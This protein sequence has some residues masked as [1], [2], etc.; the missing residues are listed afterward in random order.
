MLAAVRSAAVLGIDALDVTVEVDVVP[1]LPSWTIVGLASGAVREARERVTS[2]LANSG[3]DVP[4]RRVTVNLSPADVRKDGTSFDLPIALALLAATGAID[5]ARLA[6]VIAAGELGL[7]GTIRPIRGVLPLAR[8][9]VRAGACLVVPEANVPEAALGGGGRVAAAATLRDVGVALRT[10]GAALAEAVPRAPAIPPPP[11]ID[12]CA[13]DGALDFADV[14]GQVAAKR[15]MEIAAAG[16][17]NVMM[18][19]PPGT[20]KTMLARR[21]PGIL[22]PL[23]EEELLEVVAI[24]S[25]GGLVVPGTIPSRT[26]PFRAPH[27]TISLAGLI[28]G[29]P[30]PR[31][32][33]VSLAHRGVLFL[34]E[35]LELPRHVLDAM[36]QP[37]EDG[38]VVIARAASA[39]AFPARFQLIAAANPCKCGFSM[40]DASRCQCS[41]ADIDRY[42]A[43]LSGPLADRIDL[44]VHVGAVDISALGAARG[45]EPSAEIRKRVIGARA[46][47]RERYVHLGGV[48]NNSEAPGRWL[49]AHGS[50]TG[51]ARTLLDAAA[52]RLGI[53]ARGFH[54]AVRVARTIADLDGAPEVGAS[55]MAEAL[56]YRS[57]ATVAGT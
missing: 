17:H 34:D 28:G 11:C 40:N 7:D 29:G 16:G 33:E 26:P 41:A 44:H 24:H 53:S 51:E 6:G 19:G 13:L 43:R 35:L 55:A 50:L 22:P 48:R 14:A 20:G 46:R 54:R 15:A 18:S 27:H 3:F 9:A 47:Q 57:V 30:G 21:L 56:R 45:E 1:G 12:A 36:R 4:S 23:T 39:V 31:P 37:L 52:A 2:A 42:R 10:H 25:V 38:R 8:A 32:G 49:V 5:G